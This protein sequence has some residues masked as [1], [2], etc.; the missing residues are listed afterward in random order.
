[1]RSTVASCRRAHCTRDAAWTA[2]SLRHEWR[3]VPAR[4][5]WPHMCCV[6]CTLCTRCHL[7][8]GRV[9][10]GLDVHQA[11]PA[12]Q[13]ASARRAAELDLRRA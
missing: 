8:P 13:A 4:Q 3:C 10:A 5:Q 12:A 9:G 2:W 6:L 11:A 1:M 7:Q